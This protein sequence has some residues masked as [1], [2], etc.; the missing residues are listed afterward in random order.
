MCP[1]ALMVSDVFVTSFSVP[2]IPAKLL[3]TAISFITHHSHLIYYSSQLSH[4]LLITAISFITHHSYL[5]YYSSQPSHL[6]LITAISFI[7][8]HSHLIYYSS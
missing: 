3:I 7:T 2:F 8:H 6:L 4:L 5:I 1:L